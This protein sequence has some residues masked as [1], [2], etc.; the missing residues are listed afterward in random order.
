LFTHS[1]SALGAEVGRG[2]MLE[3]QKRGRLRDPLVLVVE[4]GGN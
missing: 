3:Q 1:P 4:T 2:R